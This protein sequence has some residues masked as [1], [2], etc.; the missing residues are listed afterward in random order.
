MARNITGSKTKI[1]HLI[2]DKF[3]LGIT[4][5]YKYLIVGS[6]GPYTP[7]FF[8]TLL[9]GLFARDGEGVGKAKIK[10]APFTQKK[11]E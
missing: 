7:S 9:L 8:N 10:R 5:Y 3:T 11:R 1:A 6:L 2:S 4:N